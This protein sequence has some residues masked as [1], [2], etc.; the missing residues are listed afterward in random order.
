MD[1]SLDQI[2]ETFQEEDNLLRLWTA[3]ELKRSGL[4][5]K[6]LREVTSVIPHYSR[7]AFHTYVGFFVANALAT[8]NGNSQLADTYL[9]ALEV[10]DFLDIELSD[11]LE[12]TDDGRP[13]VRSLRR[14]TREDLYIQV[15]HADLLWEL[16]EKGPFTPSEAT[17]ES[18]GT[19]AFTYTRRRSVPEKKEELPEKKRKE[20]RLVTTNTR[21]L[22]NFYRRRDRLRAWDAMP[23]SPGTLHVRTLHVIYYDPQR[24]EIIEPAPSEPEI[25]PGSMKID[26]YFLPTEL[27]S[28]CMLSP[29]KLRRAVFSYRIPVHFSTTGQLVIPPS[30]ELIAFLKKNR[31]IKSMPLQGLALLMG[32]EN[33]EHAYNLVQGWQLNTIQKEF[34][35]DKKVTMRRTRME[36]QHYVPPVENVLTRQVRIDRQLYQLMEKHVGER[37]PLQ[38]YPEDRELDITG[39]ARF[40]NRGMRARF[41]DQ[42]ITP[43]IFYCLFDKNVFNLELALK[44]K[45]GEQDKELQIFSAMRL[46]AIRK[47]F[48]DEEVKRAVARHYYGKKV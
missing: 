26:R 41:I 21:E 32:L 20:P 36:W 15:R 16:A 30:E 17:E 34:I 45:F 2:I 29:E 48:T 28:C 35:R 19:P 33:I 4:P 27:T 1:T 3:D 11:L 44:G 22:R 46:Y 40:F 9:P 37:G 14:E 5:K 25:M 12:L 43:E 31:T 18:T 38:V 23:P 7:G 47:S 39:A 42:Y 6:V 10:S 24:E 13:I 8:M